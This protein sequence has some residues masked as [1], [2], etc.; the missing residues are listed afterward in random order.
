MAMIKGGEGGG[1]GFILMMNMGD[2]VD[3]KA[4]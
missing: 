4:G 1:T 3:F 2:G